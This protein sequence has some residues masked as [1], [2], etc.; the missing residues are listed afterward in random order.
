MR[1]LIC[2]SWLVVLGMLA[3]CGGDVAFKA[4]DA[5]RI[6][7][8]IYWDTT[9]PLDP[10]ETIVKL[11]RLD[12][13]V[14]CMTSNNRAV[15]KDAMTG[16]TKWVAS[17]AE[18]GKPVYRPVHARR[19]NLSEDIPGIRDV[20]AH[21][22]AA[23]MFETVLF[24]TNG[25]L[26]VLNRTNG[27]IIRRMDLPFP[28]SSGGDT[29]GVFFYGG[30]VQGWFKAINIQSEVPT[31]TG[32]IGD[33][34]SAPVDVF[35]GVLYVAGQNGRFVAAKTAL[36]G[37]IAWQRRFGGPITAAF[38]VD[39]RGC[40]IPCEDNRL[41]AVSMETQEP[42]WPAFVC[43]GPLRRDVQVGERTIFQQAAGD[44]F[45]AI[46]IANGQARW[47]SAHGVDVLAVV[48]GE[49]YLRDFDNRL[50]VIDESTGVVRKT[51]SMAGFDAFVPSTGAVGIWAASRDGRVVCLR[52][53]AA[54]F[55]TKEM[56][57]QR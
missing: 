34:I 47:H 3:G 40:F 10:G 21:K 43:Q 30:S 42:L 11:Y 50:Q 24:N 36:G 26:L 8:Q 57:E 25:R 45:Y 14:Y 38:H 41:Y 33:M 52:P 1:N 54:G 7:W 39:S 51:I 6:G 15:A 31:W 27:A 5:G 18:P 49:V 16:V 23:E 32:D 55:V 29:D 20:L 12:D 48:S 35:E 19:T 4:Q 2:A 44:K 46:N 22:G 37:K 17:V 9:A 56:L 13:T 53:A 28:V